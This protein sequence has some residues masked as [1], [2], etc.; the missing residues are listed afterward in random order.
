MYT[1]AFAHF[2][3][4]RPTCACSLNDFCL[5]KPATFA[6]KLLIILNG[7]MCQLNS[8][9]AESLFYW[10]SHYGFQSLALSLSL[11]FLLALLDVTSFIW[12]YFLWYENS[13]NKRMWML[14]S[15]PKNNTPNNFGMVVDGANRPRMAN[16]R[17]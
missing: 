12:P 4:R 13:Q 9:H 11:F 7:G 5:E 16:K 6:R 3:Y 10:H 2:G 15:L 8:V 1:L 14:Y 17:T